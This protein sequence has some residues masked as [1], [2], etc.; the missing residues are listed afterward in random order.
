[1]YQSSFGDFLNFKVMITP[2]VVLV[3]FWLGMMA[4]AVAAI[5]LFA[6]GKI[7]AGIGAVFLG[8]FAW[9]IICEYM[10]I[11]FRMHDCLEQIAKEA[12]TALQ[13][14]DMV[15]KK[16]G[17][18]RSG[19]LNTTEYGVPISEISVG[20]HFETRDGMEFT[21]VEFTHNGLR[22]EFAVGTREILSPINS[23]MPE[24]TWTFDIRRT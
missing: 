9:R 20:D 13:K 14:R 19:V 22:V 16:Q 5:G 21:V 11:G 15:G 8:P 24:G 17:T 6:Q 7:L 12:E 18:G 3:L 10:I 2:V 1:M 23:G 4:I